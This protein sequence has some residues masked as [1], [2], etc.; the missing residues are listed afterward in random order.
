MKE[1][2]KFLITIQNP[3]IPDSKELEEHLNKGGFRNKVKK[4]RAGRY[5]VIVTN[6][7]RGL[8]MGFLDS[9]SL[10]VDIDCILQ[11]Q[12]VLIGEE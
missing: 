2:K 5:E 6:N 3:K 12:Q 9:S 10:E 11:K 7:D 4:I 8:H 1:V